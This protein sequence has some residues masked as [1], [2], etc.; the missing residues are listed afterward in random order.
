MVI[1][2]N[3]EPEV[4]AQLTAQA[5]ARGMDVRTY[6]ASLLEKA[7]HATPMHEEAKPRKQSLSEFFMNSPLAGS[8]LDLERGRDTGRDIDL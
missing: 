4:E 5:E 6:A 2:I 1:T 7:A 3:V 8:E